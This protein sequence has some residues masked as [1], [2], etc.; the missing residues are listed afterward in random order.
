MSTHVALPPCHAE[1]TALAKERSVLSRTKEPKSRRLR[2]PRT[3][4]RLHRV[5]TQRAPNTAQPQTPRRCPLAKRTGV[6]PS[7]PSPRR[8]HWCSVPPLRHP[9]GP[10]LLIGAETRRLVLS[11]VKGQKIDGTTMSIG[12]FCGSRILCGRTGETSGGFENTTLP[13]DFVT[14]ENAKDATRSPCLRTLRPHQPACPCT[15]TP[16]PAS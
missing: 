8:R 7:A 12:Y 6:P 14:E 16:P 5:R 9:S 15:K 4:I 3:P 13:I 10:I 1:A 2:N 11:A